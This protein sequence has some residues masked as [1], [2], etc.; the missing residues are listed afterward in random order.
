MSV[1]TGAFEHL[2]PEDRFNRARAIGR[3]TIHLRNA[4]DAIRRGMHGH[5]DSEITAALRALNT[6]GGQD[7]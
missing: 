3:A 5:A 4:S 2:L 6:S 1:I 7:V